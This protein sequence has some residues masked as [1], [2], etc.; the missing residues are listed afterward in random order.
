MTHLASFCSCGIQQSLTN[1]RGVS[2]NY[3]PKRFK[4]VTCG[5]HILKK[6]YFYHYLPT[7]SNFLSF[8]SRNFPFSPQTLNPNFTFL[9]QKLTYTFL[10]QNGPHG[11]HYSKKNY[12]NFTVHTDITLA[13][14]EYELYRWMGI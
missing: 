13:E 10:L 4:P 7:H 8:L 11:V 1:L 9:P 5:P 12:D 6:H 14:L 2:N 3:A